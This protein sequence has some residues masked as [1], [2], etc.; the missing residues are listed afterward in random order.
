MTNDEYQAAKQLLG[1]LD[2]I[3]AELGEWWTTSTQIRPNGMSLHIKWEKHRPVMAT[4]DLGEVFASAPGKLAGVLRMLVDA[5]A[6]EN[7][8]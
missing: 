6:E 2:Q 5:H 7:Q 1:Q 8:R 3:G 4:P